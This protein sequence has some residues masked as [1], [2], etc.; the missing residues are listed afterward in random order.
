MK[1]LLLLPSFN[2]RE[3]FYALISRI[4][5]FPCATALLIKKKISNLSELPKL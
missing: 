2:G 4:S 5:D 1:L 3:F